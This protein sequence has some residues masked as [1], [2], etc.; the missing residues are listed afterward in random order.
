MSLDLLAVTAGETVGGAVGANLLRRIELAKM[1]H[2][3]AVGQGV[4]QVYL[5]SGGRRAN[6]VHRVLMVNVLHGCA[7]G[8]LLSEV[9]VPLGCV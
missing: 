5:G 6:L 9:H 1:L 8:R 2:G 3:C 7:V 4:S